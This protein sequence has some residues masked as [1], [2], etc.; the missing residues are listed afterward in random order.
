MALALDYV[1]GRRLDELA[2]EEIDAELLDAVWHEVVVHAPRAGSRTDRSAP[3]TS[4][5]T[6]GRPVIID[7]GFGEESATPRLQAIDR[8]ELLVSLAEI[9]GA[10]AGRRVGRAELERRRRWR[11]PRPYLQPLALSAATRKQRVEGAARRI[12]ATAIAD[13]HAARSPPPLERLVRV[14]ART[15]VMIAALTGGVLRAAPAARPRRRQL[16][17]ARPRRLAVADRVRPDVAA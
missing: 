8:A 11:P 13:D 16:R 3:R 1:D 17:G 7:L 6:D 5:S 2:P 10:G 9:V 14:R 12:C 4:S 15:L